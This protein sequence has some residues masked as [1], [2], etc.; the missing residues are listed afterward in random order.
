M[1]QV[2]SNKMLCES[3]NIDDA[4]SFFSDTNYS[5]SYTPDIGE[6]GI[7]KVFATWSA[8]A[9]FHCSD[10]S[11]D[12]DSDSDSDNDYAYYFYKKTDATTISIQRFRSANTRNPLVSYN[13]YYNCSGGKVGDWANI[14]PYNDSGTIKVE[15][16]DGDIGADAMWA[17][18][19][20]MIWTYICD[21]GAHDGHA[22]TGFGSGSFWYSAIIVKQFQKA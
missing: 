5:G 7:I 9:V 13:W 21:G 11:V 16:D 1:G 22:G 2:K 3:V 12:I 15:T 10:C 8:S 20:T 17:I 19:T 18:D 4:T 14:Y 6:C